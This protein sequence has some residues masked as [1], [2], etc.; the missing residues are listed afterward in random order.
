[1]LA[2]E[3]GSIGS[4]DAGEL[5]RFSDVDDLIDLSKLHV[6]RN[7]YKNR[8]RLHSGGNRQLAISVLDC[9]K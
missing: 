6:R 2:H 1:M 8:L 9:G 4:D 7:F 5:R 3:S